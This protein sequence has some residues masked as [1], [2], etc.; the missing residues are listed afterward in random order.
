MWISSGETFSVSNI[1][2]PASSASD[3][4]S[5]DEEQEI[6]STERIENLAENSQKWNESN[7]LENF[8]IWSWAFGSSI[9]MPEGGR[10][11]EKM[12]FFHTSGFW[13][14]FPCVCSMIKG[15]SCSDLEIGFILCSQMMWNATSLVWCSS[16]IL[17]D[18]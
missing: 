7:M 10:K 12:F 4:I 3:L 6:Q 14:W 5:F 8:W 2:S 11:R 16:Y 17:Q 1:T 18:V 9:R 15:H 13:R